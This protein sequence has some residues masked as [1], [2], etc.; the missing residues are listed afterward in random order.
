MADLPVPGQRPARRQV[1]QR[2][3]DDAQQEQQ[4]AIVWTVAA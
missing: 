4:I 2:K 1:D 3:Q